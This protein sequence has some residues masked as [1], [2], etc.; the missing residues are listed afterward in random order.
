MTTTYSELHG[1]I[2]DR[3]NEAGIEIMSPHYS[4]IRDGNPLTLPEDHLPKNYEP[5]P[6][7]LYVLAVPRLAPGIGPSA[8][9]LSRCRSGQI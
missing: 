8:R 4:A 6:F 3:F 5:A 9:N 2:V 1:H 7:R